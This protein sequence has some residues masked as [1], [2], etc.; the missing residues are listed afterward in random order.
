MKR[1][2]IHLL[3]FVPVL[4]LGFITGCQDDE[5]IPSIVLDGPAPTATFGYTV[6]PSNP[7]EVTFNNTSA[8]GE[9]Y[10]WQ[11]G[12]GTSSTEK[13]PKHVYA[14]EGKYPVKLTTRSAAGYSLTSATEVIAA[15]DAIADFTSDSFFSEI[16]F[17]NNSTAIETATWDFGDNTSST[18]ISPWH[19]YVNTGT[20][21]VILTIKGLKG[22]TAVKTRTVTVT[23][24]NLIKGGSFE[25]GDNQYWSNWSS[26]NSNPPVYNYAGDKP[27]GALGNVLRF[28][29][30]TNSTGST[31]QLIYQAVQV[32]AG[33]KYKLSA[34]VKA[35]AGASQ[36]YFQFYISNDANTWV[37]NT[38]SSAN[39]FLTINTWWGWGT[40]TN[41]V[42]A[43][44]DL[45]TL[46][47]S[48]SSYGFGSATNGVYTAATTR[49]VYIGVQAG[50]YQGKSNGDWLL[51]NLS[52][53]EV[54]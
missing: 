27:T 5:T 11:F 18:A 51:D 39:H 15:N 44:G 28:P 30:F 26:Q 4:M 53:V 33:K 24:K 47:K 20:Y 14:G 35:P 37:E 23:G 7:K 1:Y 10:F 42:A 41:S 52:F 13:S 6:T 17:S 45:L 29:S 16:L 31:N 3:T 36:C 49:T 54:P 40:Q 25:E 32:E 21:T 38:S 8:N 43:N 2:F 50:T 34:V 22:N 48:F 12:D 19:K 46:A 9:S